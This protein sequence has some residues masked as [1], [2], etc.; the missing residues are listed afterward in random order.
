M[1]TETCLKVLQIT[2]TH[3]YGEQHQRL[4]GVDTQRA[5]EDIVDKIV[6]ERWPADLVLATGDIA[7]DGSEAAYRRFKRRFEA[8]GVP[9]LVIP[10]NHDAP[11]VLREVMQGGF[12]RS[13]FQHVLGSW[14]FLMLDSTL[15]GSDGGHLS[16]DQLARLEQALAAHPDRHA[17][18]CLH[19]HPVAMNCRWID[20]IGVANAE[21]LFR[22]LDGHPQVRAVVWGHVHQDFR[23][24]RRGVQLLASP[25]TCI[26]FKPREADFNLDDIPAGYRWLNLY[27]DG[28]IETAVERL[29]V[30][31]Y[32]LDMKCSG[33]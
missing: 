15:A 2:D 19:H 28:R 30:V 7:Q 4:V 22:V 9:T 32:N 5:W 8:L 17:L 16:A 20:P 11:E 10:G 25:S 14:Q 33:Y 24:E 29:D 6:A 1:S 31:P 18:I 27:A 21:E 3:L 26:Q 23:A 13:Q 12:V